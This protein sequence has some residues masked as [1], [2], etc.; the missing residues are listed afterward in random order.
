MLKIIQIKKEVLQLKKKK[1]L[2]TSKAN[3][4]TPAQKDTVKIGQTNSETILTEIRPMLSF[5]QVFL[6]A[7][8]C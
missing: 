4:L 7:C 8:H 5:T 3:L 2:T 1:A 6:I